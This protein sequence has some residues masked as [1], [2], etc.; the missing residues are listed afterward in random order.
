MPIYTPGR[1]RTMIILLL[2]SI[3]LIT[4]DLRGNALLDAGR[5]G[6]GYA[7]RPFEIAAEVVTRPIVR[8]WAGITEVDDLQEENQELRDELDAARGDLV[9]AENALIQNQQ[10]RQLLELQSLAEYDR[11]TC[12]TIG[13][14]PS[15]DVQTVEID[16][17]TLDGLRTGMPVMNAAGLVGKITRA[18]PETAIVMLLTDPSY[19]MRVKV[20]GEEAPA[21]T[22]PPTT[23]PS[24]LPVDSIDEI[25]DALNTTT[26]TTTTI[27]GATSTTTTTTTPGTSV[28]PS[29]LPGGEIGTG[30][31]PGLNTTTTESTTTTTLVR[32][33]RET[34]ML[35]GVGGDQLPRVGLIADSPQFTSPSVGDVVLTTGGERD[36]AP[37][38]L[39]VGRVA[40]IIRR[41]GTEGLVLEVEPN[42]DLTRLDF[43]TVVLYQPATEMP[44]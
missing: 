38:D 26:T 8:A 5:S 33:T 42:A 41:P 29:S 32:V 27:P 1:R 34:G 28:S 31:P 15:N 30:G 2:T 11:V 4:I 9:A 13:A 3:M 19:A 40:N 12:G 24:G 36:L 25:A 16:C 6:F 39:P 21:V 35:N 23:T 7:F 43:L 44:G 18:A 10:M 37:P 14:S 20:V 17:G 22:A